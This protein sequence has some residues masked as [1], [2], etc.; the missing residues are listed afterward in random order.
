MRRSTRKE[1]AAAEPAHSQFPEMLA[2]GIARGHPIGLV[3]V[4]E[5]VGHEG[6]VE[7]AKAGLDTQLKPAAMHGQIEGGVTRDTRQLRQGDVEVRNGDVL[8]DVRG[9]HYVERSGVEHRHLMNAAHHVRSKGL[10]DV[11]GGDVVSGPPQN[12]GIESLA[13]PHHQDPF[14]GAETADVAILVGRIDEIRAVDLLAPLLAIYGH[15]RGRRN[16]AVCGAALHDG[17]RSTAKRMTRYL[18]SHE[19]KSSAATFAARYG[20]PDRRRARLGATW[21]RCAWGRVPLARTS[22]PALRPSSRRSSSDI[23]Y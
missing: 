4:I 8:E 22:N 14:D 12:G 17:L 20:S 7:V 5:H 23:R 18:S 15:D 11:E 19:R 6:E 13:R 21:L 3:P 9:C 1:V 16:V 2:G 10:I